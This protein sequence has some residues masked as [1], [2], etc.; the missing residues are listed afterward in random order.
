MSLAVAHD[1]DQG[2]VLTEALVNAGKALGMSQA[3][4]GAVIGKDRTAISRGRIDPG[5]KAGELA[6]LLIRCYRALYVLV[7]GNPQH[8]QH[9]MRTEN[10]HTGG[11]PAEQI[12]TVQG[13]TAVLAYLD[14]MR[15]KL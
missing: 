4:L 1:I 8:M 6:L 9:W 14:A 2:S 10:L 12:K 7:G 15:G 11:I 5:S 3:D 13:L